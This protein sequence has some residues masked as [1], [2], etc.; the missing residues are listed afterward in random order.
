MTRKDQES[1][2]QYLAPD[3]PASALD[4]LYQ[5]AAYR[6]GKHRDYES[7]ITEVAEW[8]DEALLMVQKVEKLPESEQT[9]P[10]SRMFR[11]VRR[12]GQWLFWG[13]HF[14]PDWKPPGEA[15]LQLGFI[16]DYAWRVVGTIVAPAHMLEN[17]E[18][19]EETLE[20]LF[21]IHLESLSEPLTFVADDHPDAYLNVASLWENEQC[22]PLN[23]YQMLEVSES[24]DS[25]LIVVAHIKVVSPDNRWVKLYLGA[26]GQ[27]YYSWNGEAFHR[28]GALP[29]GNQFNP[30]DLVDG[31]QGVNLPLKQGDNIIRVFLTRDASKTDRPWGAIARMTDSS[32]IPANAIN[33]L[34]FGQE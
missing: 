18:S 25:V 3:A 14:P 4:L 6:D 7:R 34:R 33:N 16:P 13:N 31:K 9:A 1:I 17:F 11:W 12:D 26:A 30:I 27:C 8:K 22:P 19:G 15:L 29:G 28:A 10:I 24:E 20:S 5:E 23:S 32:G 21:E 2:E